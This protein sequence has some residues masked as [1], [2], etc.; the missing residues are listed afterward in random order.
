[1]NITSYL[2]EG[3]N[4]IDLEGSIGIEPELENL[5]L[6]GD[7]GV[8][9]SSKGTSAI[10]EERIPK[11]TSNLVNQG[12]PF[13][14]GS[15]ELSNKFSYN[16]ETN[17]GIILKLEGLKAALAIVYVNDQE[18]GKVFI[19]PFS[20]DITK[21]IRKGEND[22]RIKV[23][24]TLRNAFGPLHYAGGDPGWIGPEQFE[25]ERHWTDDYILKPIGLEKIELVVYKKV[26]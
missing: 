19:Y 25:D 17:D 16:G 13:Y 4:E 20:L 22:L 5:F 15:F 10:V 18:A 6:V 9:L 21:F 3:K 23:I 2:K 14:V 8:E 11:E 24:G 7:F 1:M 12:Y 26:S